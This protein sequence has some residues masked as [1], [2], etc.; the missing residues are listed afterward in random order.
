MTINRPRADPK[1]TGRYNQDRAPPQ[2]CRAVLS[3]GPLVSRS[4]ITGHL[5]ADEAV[6]LLN[7]RIDFEAGG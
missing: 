5:E 4:L 7:V 3:V 6:T 1:T 2:P